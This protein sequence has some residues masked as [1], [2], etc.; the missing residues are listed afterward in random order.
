M[1]EN[2]GQRRRSD[3]KLVDGRLRDACRVSDKAILDLCSVEDSWHMEAADAWACARLMAR[4]SKH[5]AVGRAVDKI[6]RQRI[7]YQFPR[8]E[9]VDGDERKR[10]RGRVIQRRFPIGD[11]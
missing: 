9:A 5:V 3:A 4:D 2:V 8:F 7:L 11:G 6:E 1:Q 10:H